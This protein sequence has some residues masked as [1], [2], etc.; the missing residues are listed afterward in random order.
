MSKRGR[1]SSR[2]KQVAVTL[3]LVS[4]PSFFAGPAW[5]AAYE[6]FASLFIFFIYSYYFTVPRELWSFCILSFDE[7]Q[8]C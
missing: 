7:Y 4:A 5:Q 3:I 2:I 8:E 1:K 6:G